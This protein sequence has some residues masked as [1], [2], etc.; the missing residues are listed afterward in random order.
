MKDIYK[1][2]WILYDKPNQRVTMYYKFKGE[3][4]VKIIFNY[5][6]GTPDYY[7]GSLRDHVPFSAEEEATFIE[8][9]RMNASY[10]LSQLKE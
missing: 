3:K 9:K 4:P 7:E 5:K 8:V 6:E 10:R 1:E 2:D